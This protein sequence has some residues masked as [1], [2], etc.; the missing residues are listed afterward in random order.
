MFMFITGQCT[1]ETFNSW[2]VKKYCKIPLISSGLIQVQGHTQ[3]KIMTEAMSM[4]KIMTEAMSVV[5]LSV[6]GVLNEKND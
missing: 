6:L 1:T 3:K 4:V 2:L 5:K